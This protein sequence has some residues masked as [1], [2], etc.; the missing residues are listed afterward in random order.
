M[1][2]K[3]RFEMREQT[4]KALSLFTEKANL[5]LSFS[6]I[7]S[8]K[9]GIRLH[10][11][12]GSD[13]ETTV[14]F[15]GPDTEAVHAFLNTYRFFIQDSDGISFRALH[16]TVSDDPGLSDNWKSEFARVRE[17]LN[18]FLDEPLRAIR[19]VFNG[20]PI[21]SRREVHD[22]F[23]Y[24]DISHLRYKQDEQKREIFERWRSQPDI[25]GSLWLVFIDTLTEM[26]RAIA[27]I[28]C[29]NEEVLEAEQ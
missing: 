2:S 16:R 7:E 14:E 19:I 21:S 12:G 1:T 29:L 22:V 17:A 15:Y 6:F 24:G 28:S 27:Y 9:N 26:L 8:V 11:S 18:E 13:K 4:R 5:L 3:R 25:Y 23:I 10:V 20:R